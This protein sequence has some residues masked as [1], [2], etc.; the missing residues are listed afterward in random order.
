MTT[1]VIR[2]DKDDQGV[3]TL[4]LDDP[5]A[6][7]NTMTDDFRASLSDAV[8][9]LEKDDSVT[10]VI[11]T[12]AKST[13]RRSVVDSRSRWPATTA[14]PWTT[15][16]PSSACPRSPWACCPARAASP[17]SCACSASPTG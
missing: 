12:S 8:D 17:A 10:G 6:R 1:N 2:W 14:S 5:N 13:A 7:A 3:V 16:R 9:R 15:R 11:V 4:T